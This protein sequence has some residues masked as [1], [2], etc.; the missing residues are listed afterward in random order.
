MM[1]P[2]Q[3][4]SLLRRHAQENYNFWVSQK[5]EWK[6]LT[7]HYHERISELGVASSNYIKR[8]ELIKSYLS[9]I[10]EFVAIKNHKRWCLYKE[11]QEELLALT[12]TINKSKQ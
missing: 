1:S 5:A 4:S 9:D 3:I 11:H 7:G 6:E 10:T 8:A 12:G 2:T